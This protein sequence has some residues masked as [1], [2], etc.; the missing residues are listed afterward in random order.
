VRSRIEAL[1]ALDLIAEQGEGFKLGTDSHFE[2]F[3]AIYDHFES[4]LAGHIAPVAINPRTS[5]AGADQTPITHAAALLWAKLFNARYELVLLKLALALQ[6]PRGGGG[7]GVLS[8]A[9]LFQAAVEEMRVGVR[10]VADRLAVFSRDV[11][12]GAP[13]EL[14][15]TPFPADDAGIRQR[16]R[17]VIP[18]AAAVM[19]S[20][21]ELTGSD[22]LTA[23]EQSSLGDL[24]TADEALLAALAA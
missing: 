20:M 12:A 21:G 11:A 14:P 8:R 15:A 4:D 6:Q 9:N 3:L 2:R 19:Q 22:A 7:S 10:D 17:Q 1:F 23:A 24:Q 13:F 5:N 16:V 18:A